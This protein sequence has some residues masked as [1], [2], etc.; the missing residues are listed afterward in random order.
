MTVHAPLATEFF[1]YV[2]LMAGLVAVVLVRFLPKRS[3]IIALS[4]LTGW[5]IYAGALGYAGV[6]RGQSFGIPG[7]VVLLAPIFVFVA[8]VLVR[9]PA[10]RDIALLIPLPLLIALQSFRVGVEFTLHK[11]WEAGA[12]PALLTLSGGNI[13]ILIGLSAP[14][15]AWLSRKGDIGHRIALGWSVIGLLSLVNVASRSVLTSPG[16]LSWIHS[17]V[18]NVAMGMFPYT[19]IPGFMAP[20]AVMLHVLALRAIR[21]APYGSRVQA[22]G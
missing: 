12:V 6:V 2:A 1:A 15:I 17:E 11:L 9:S 16:P 18:P 22:A 10:G 3:A 14:G 4:L 19:F 5:L 7:I 8:V 20:L 13:E 21:N